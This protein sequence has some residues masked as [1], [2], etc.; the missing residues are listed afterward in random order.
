MRCKS[1][2][3]CRL[4][5][6]SKFIYP[7]EEPKRVWP[8]NGWSHSKRYP[9]RR[10]FFGSGRCRQWR[11]KHVGDWIRRKSSS[12]PP[13]LRERS[14]NWSD[15]VCRISLDTKNTAC[16]RRPTTF[17]HRS[18]PARNFPGHSLGLLVCVRFI[19]HSFC[20]LLRI[21]KLDVHFG[22]ISFCAK[23]EIML[24]SFGHCCFIKDPV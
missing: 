4:L 10:Q 7:A 24:I 20:C 23:F 17:C 9:S 2:T 16:R 22:S 1:R 5:G 8:G 14:K 11:W 6:H 12:L 21:N 13:V 3:G 18:S 15:Y 19:Q